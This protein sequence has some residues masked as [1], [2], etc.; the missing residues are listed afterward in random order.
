MKH[1]RIFN[2]MEEFESTKHSI[3]TPFVVLEKGTPKVIYSNIKEITEPE[4]P[5]YLCFEAIES[6]TLSF[7][8]YGN[9]SHCKLEYAVGTGDFSTYTIGTEIQLNSGD[10]VYFRGDNS[11]ISTGEKKYGHF[12]GTGKINI[13]GNILSLL[14]KDL[15]PV[16]TLPN[17]CFYRLFS[18][19][20]AFVSAEKLILPFSKVGQYS[21]KN[22]FYNCGSL[23]TA[24]ELLPAETLAIDCYWGMFADCKS[25]TK[26]PALPATT[27]AGSCYYYMFNNCRNLT[28]AP[29]LPAKTLAYGCYSYMF[30][31]CTS[32]TTAPV[33]HATTLA[34][35]C[36][37][38]MFDGCTS[39]TTVP[40][41]PATTLADMC[42]Y[43]MFN[44]CRNLTTVPLLPAKTLAEKCYY[45][46]F[47]G[48]SKLSTIKC[49]AEDISA[50][51]CTSN[52]VNGVASSGTFI[53]SANATNWE[54]GAHGIPSGWTVIDEP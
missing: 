23:T 47:Y 18:V 30:A 33:L 52:W 37:Y 45:Y 38:Y 54:T 2:S 40:E 53:K 49:L 5:N 1:L 26:A 44:N 4:I 6:S 35:R 36:Y 42:Y 32:L 48:C 27:L 13:S 46:M 34:S 51:Y 21:C 29:E 11:T 7:N 31:G 15:S 10:K 9:M 14:S 50:T 3:D 39:L 8:A 17:Y 22:M 25:L 41:L 43:F 12:S 16:D 28:T 24:P 20:G 19:C